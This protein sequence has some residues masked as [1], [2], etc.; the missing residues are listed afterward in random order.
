MT[1]TADRGDFT[2][3][4]EPQAVLDI[5]SPD[6]RCSVCSFTTSLSGQWTVEDGRLVFRADADP[7][8][9]RGPDFGGCSEGRQPH[10]V[11]GVTVDYGHRRLSDEE[12]AMLRSA[13]DAE[14][15]RWEDE[16]GV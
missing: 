10:S 12:F 4:Q 2:E 14:R 6:V 16:H 11:V 9:S 7:L 5:D 3:D 13:A 1:H 15:Q 8:Q